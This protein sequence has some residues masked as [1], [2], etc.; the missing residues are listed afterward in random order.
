MFVTWL[1]CIFRVVHILP[2]YSLSINKIFDDG[3]DS[4]RTMPLFSPS[5]FALALLTS[6]MYI[7]F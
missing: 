6:T 7:K 4:L 2:L 1:G 3:V 5:R